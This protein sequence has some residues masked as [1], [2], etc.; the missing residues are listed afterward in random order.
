M[1]SK[2]LLLGILLLFFLIIITYEIYEEF[3]DKP[4][5]VGAAIRDNKTCSDSDMSY[6]IDR[7]DKAR[8]KPNDGTCDADYEEGS[9]FPKNVPLSQ[10]L[11]YCLP[12]CEKLGPY[13]NYSNDD[14]FCV[15][16]DNRCGLN[17]NLSN[18]IE[19]NWTHVCGPL[20][21]TNLNLLST[22]GSISTVV[23][24]VNSQYGVVN[25]N[26]PAFSNAVVLNASGLPCNS[27]L[28]DTL[29][30]V[31][32]ISNY[33]DLTTINNSIDSYWTDLSNRKNRFDGVFNS[34]NCANY[35]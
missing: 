11:A 22:M 15:R 19:N 13:I 24:T 21:K 25:T 1:N 32:I 26:F 17:K 9:S 30:N 35:M 4:V 33:Y 18:S 20:Y 14:T 7:F 34:L 10:S 31:N 5:A 28:R 2:Y 16:S 12:R 8:L 29:F 3:A 27:Y 23:S 6:M